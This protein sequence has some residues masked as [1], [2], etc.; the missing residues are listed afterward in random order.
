[1]FLI[2]QKETL[3]YNIGEIRIDDPYFA[4]LN[5]TNGKAILKLEGKGSYVLLSAW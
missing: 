5:A 3:T 4:C 1:M 2:S